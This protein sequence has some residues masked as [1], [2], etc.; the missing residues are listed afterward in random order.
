MP[1][2]NW[3][4]K[5][6]P[7]RIGESS[8][9][10]SAERLVLKPPPLGCVGGVSS[11]VPLTGVGSDVQGFVTTAGVELRTRRSAQ[12]CGEGWVEMSMTRKRRRVTLRDRKSTR[13]NSSHAN[14]SYAVF[15]L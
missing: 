2:R 8:V 13:L 10:V 12:P 9:T 7:G 3:K 14:I 11:V 1:S 5:V 6:A 15:C 4:S